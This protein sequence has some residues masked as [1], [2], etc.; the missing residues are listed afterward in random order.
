MKEFGPLH[1][2]LSLLVRN[3]DI[4]I[5]ESETD[6]NEDAGLNPYTIPAKIAELVPPSD[7]MHQALFTID[8][9]KRFIREVSDVILE[10]MKYILSPSPT[11]CTDTKR[12]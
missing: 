12:E 2:T 4:S 9:S 11:V 8:C 5:F 7:G 1:C 6:S 10:M 3:T